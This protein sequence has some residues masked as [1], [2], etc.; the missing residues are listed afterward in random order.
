[1]S[2]GVQ[3]N[4]NKPMRDHPQMRFGKRENKEDPANLVKIG[5]YSHPIK[6]TNMIVIRLTENAVPY[7][8]AGIYGEGNRKI[9]DIHEIFGKFDDHVYASIA[10]DSKLDGSKYN[11]DSLFRADKFRCLSF[12]RVK[13]ASQINKDGKDVKKAKNLP[14][15]PVNRGRSSKFRTKAQNEKISKYAESQIIQNRRDARDKGK[16]DEFLR[17]TEE[18]RGKEV[19]M[20]KKKTFTYDE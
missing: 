5:E 3:K 8:N 11:K 15:Q 17:K 14:K 7:F 2:R 16:R 6:N 20:H 1:M 19:K 4:Q 10:I 18:K 13:G 9:A 12:D